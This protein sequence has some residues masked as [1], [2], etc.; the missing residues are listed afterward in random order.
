[1][2]NLT[3][4]DK[5]EQSLFAEA[6]HTQRQQT[7]LSDLL[8]LRDEAVRAAESELDER[9]QADE[10]AIQARFESLEN[11]LKRRLQ[12]LIDATQ[13]EYQGRVKQVETQ[14]ESDSNSVERETKAA[15]SRL[16]NQ[17]DDAERKS[18]IKVERTGWLAESH[19]EVTKT[20]LYKEFKRVKEEAPAKT[21]LID[22]IQRKADGLLEEFRQPPPEPTDQPVEELPPEK[23]ADTSFRWEC[24]VAQHHVE[25]LG[26]LWLPR[27]FTGSRP[28]VAAAFL[29]IVPVALVAWLTFASK[30]D[31]SS[32]LLTCAM[33]LASALAI[34]LIGGFILRRVVRSQIHAIYNPM[35]QALKKARQA[36][37]LWSR[38]AAQELR[39]R[40][41]QAIKKRDDE[42]EK[43]KAEKASIVAKI[44]Q[45]RHE[46]LKQIEETSS[47][48]RTDVEQRKT[49]GMN[50]ADDWLKTNATLLK[51]R[52]DRYF[53]LAR[54]RHDG[55]TGRYQGRFSSARSE[56]EH[57]WQNGLSR[58]QAL[59]EETDRLNHLD[60]RNWNDPAWQTWTPPHE[61]ASIF[62]F[63][64]LHVD[65][66]QI[67][68]DVLQYGRLRVDQN[69]ELA[70]PALLNFPDRCSLLIETD[71]EGR[72]EATRAVQAVM[73]RLLTSLPPGRV[74]FIIIDPLGLGENFAGFMHLA[75]HDEK[76]VGN[77][78][79]TDSTH[80]EQRL[81]DL[82]DHMENV[83]QKYLR[84][85]FETIEA[86]NRQA[87]E[88]AE[89][90]RFL[91]I[92]NFPANFNELAVRRLSSIVNSGARCGVYTLIAH[93]TRQRVPH[94]IEMD[95]VRERSI[96]V[97]R[98]NGRFVLQ[99]DVFRQ[100]PLT[101]DAPPSDEILTRLMHTAGEAAIQLSRVE[102]P[103]N[104]IA[105]H[106]EQY[107]TSDSSK[108][109]RVPIGRTGATRLQ[110]LSLGQGVAQHA[111][112][113]GKTGSGK[114]TLLHV[115]VTN[116]ALRFRPDEVEFYLVDFKKG[117]EFKSYA[118]HE[119]PHARAIAIESDREFG[120]SVLQRLDAEMDR[121]G[122]LFRNVG[123]QDLAS[124]RQ[125]NG[126][127]PLPRSL[128]VID[129]F[130]V[131]FAEDDKLAHD[132]SMLLD[133]LVRQGRAF[134]IHVVLGSQT[135]AGTSGLPRSTIGQMAVRI[136][137][138]CSEA[139]SQMILNDDNT[140]ARL[141][142]RPGEAIYNDAG[143]LIEGNSP[144]QTSW[145]PD[146]KRDQYLEHVRNLS[147]GS[148]DRR[149]PTI[150]FEGN[151]PADIRKNR[152]LTH[153]L[154]A[155]DWPTRQSAPQVWLGEA[156][157]IKDPTS[158]SFRRQSGANMVMLGQRDD[159]AIGLTTS[160]IVALAAQH[161]PSAADFYILDGCAA[162]SAL[163]GTLARVTSALPHTTTMVEWRDVAQTISRL[164]EEM[165]R[166][167]EAEQTDAPAI[168]L[169]I[170]GLQRYRMLRRSE[171]DFSFSMD[172]EKQGPTPDKQ[173]AELLREGPAL[174]MHTITWVDTLT[175]LERTLDRQSMHEFDHRV[176]FQMSASDSS[177]LID[178]PLAN[179]L[180]F[181]RAL[182]SSEEQGILEKFRPY[183]LLDD[184]WLEHV[185]NCFQKRPAA[186]A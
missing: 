30:T 106:D 26:A 50:E 20:Q 177:R 33:T 9:F 164:A 77:R 96:V 148:S 125:T 159:A 46:S 12:K 84:N 67:S 130:Q 116:I 113:A 90:Y 160:A 161:A 103:F 108:E 142:S 183:A 150:V 181:Y 176:L 27:F 60:C 145:L 118:T 126:S 36:V 80:I 78:I 112:I 110:H 171:D 89:P 154:D 170:F 175:S 8:N 69:P 15:H 134:G 137:L 42:V 75:D 13:R 58:I 63:G 59:V 169:L 81:S 121:R 16:T 155:P 65:L 71:Q 61:F 144:F 102:V 95:D 109:L 76:L 88:L 79:W 70:V 28:Y 25:A 5:Q 3:G 119:L 14:Y 123:V 94:G 44:S 18:R 4:E 156:I 85:E 179:K 135:L 6:N 186:S 184:L 22:S 100:F 17:A 174:G 133:R 140:A 101:L 73:A 19:L 64:Q 115:I 68:E 47:R 66:K 32:Y 52:Y 131:F 147:R 24:E 120:L 138:Q 173:F 74:H 48:L 162:D 93:D 53:E 172:A 166:R 82:T 56:L 168:Y 114:S 1:M 34:T 141:L 180:G 35:A 167:Q 83:I 11:K 124:Y 21:K 87:G 178:S 182:L 37:E 51:E 10:T 99:N 185:S 107:W 39:E 86:Y 55:F 2:H 62:R 139:D 29:L 128:L 117:V 91:V 105:P 111:L 146:E 72:D 92:T 158:A 149:E 129:E 43:A 57:Q 151:A 23:D 104:I 54:Q 97:A 127:Q 132:A 153:L 45:Q 98:E 122:E 31:W 165:Q 157:T 152:Q 40:E 49:I 163:A 143:G 38:Q 136:A 7:A 41:A